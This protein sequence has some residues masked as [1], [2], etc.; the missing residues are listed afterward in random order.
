MRIQRVITRQG[1]P[2]PKT[3]HNPKGPFP[4]ELFQATEII[5]DYIP[6]DDDVPMGG[7]A[8]NNFVEPKLFKCKNC[9]DYVYEHQISDHK[10][11][12]IENGEDS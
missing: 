6:A 1:H 8:Q 10:C 12:G 11:E 3:A 9:S 4:P 5:V 7:T 2:V